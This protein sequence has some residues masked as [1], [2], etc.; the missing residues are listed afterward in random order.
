MHKVIYDRGNKQ[1]LVNI[2]KTGYA[3]AGSVILWDERVDGLIPVGTLANLGALER[4]GSELVVNQVKLAEVQADRT[5][6][7]TAETQKAQRIAQAKQALNQAQ[8]GNADA[9]LT[10]QQIRQMFR[11][12]RVILKDVANQLD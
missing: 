2:S 3:P 8:L 5:A 10:P 12:I 7:E 4:V 9:D 11:F 6:R 1:F